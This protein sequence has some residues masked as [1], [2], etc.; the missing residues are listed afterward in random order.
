[1]S[2][3]SCSVTSQLIKKFF[4]NLTPPSPISTTV[5]GRFSVHR[6]LFHTVEVLLL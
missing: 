5:W 2:F 6:V 3:F 1:M 4:L